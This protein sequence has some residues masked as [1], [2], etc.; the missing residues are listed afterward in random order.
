M[1]R[2][3]SNPAIK[4]PRLLAARGVAADVPV[5]GTS[6]S[7]PT[8]EPLSWGQMASVLDLIASLPGEWFPAGHV[9]W[10]LPK[11]LVLAQL[12]ESCLRPSTLAGS[13]Q[14][15]GEQREGEEGEGGEE[16][17][18]GD[19][20]PMRV[21]VSGLRL[22]STLATACPI[23]AAACVR[24]KGM[25]RVL[26][27]CLRPAPCALRPAAARRAGS[28]AHEVDV[29]F[30]ELVQ[31]LSAAALAASGFSAADDN[32]DGEVG[33]EV[34]SEVGSHPSECFYGHTARIVLARV[35]VGRPSEAMW[36]DDRSAGGDG[37]G[38]TDGGGG[39]GGAGLLHVAAVRA[40]TAHL[41]ALA[42]S[43]PPPPALSRSSGAP[44][45]SKQREARDK[46]PRNAEEAT[47][48]VVRARAEARAVARAQRAAEWLGIVRSS[49]LEPMVVAA[50][51]AGGGGGGGEKKQKKKKEKS[52][53][54]GRRFPASVC[55]ALGHGRLFRW[56]CGHAPPTP[57]S[58]RWTGRSHRRSALVPRRVASLPR[59]PTRPSWPGGTS[60]ASAAQP[61]CA[62][63]HATPRIIRLPRGVRGVERSA[64]PPPL[65]LP[66][67]ANI[68]EGSVAGGG[69]EVPILFDAEDEDE[70]EE[71]EG[72]A[73]VARKAG[74]A[75]AA[76]QVGRLSS[77][78]RLC[79]PLLLGAV[80]HRRVERAARRA[81][82]DARISEREISSSS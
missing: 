35:G 14:F 58:K 57:R 59:P 68:N 1:A 43:L 33:G 55:V 75:A 2:L 52:G 53:G 19:A 3:I 74:V 38:G 62:A 50:A 18:G 64:Q 46:G 25:R 40:L 44:A 9:Q 24:G 56:R 17:G 49:L 6:S 27:W 48:V 5:E 82:R 41:A 39:D 60:S 28:A 16:A 12:A 7:L 63:R 77:H 54:G 73:R 76:T 22:A 13:H 20:E 70:E 78:P 71:D 47:A 79:L 15:D 69:I 61:R 36:S 29:A 10:L 11:A 67:P 65:P 34:G 30:E 72:G 26:Q 81:A 8:M 45:A 4:R 66:T 31:A 32:A 37:G 80:P 51:A 23:A 42:S 21:L